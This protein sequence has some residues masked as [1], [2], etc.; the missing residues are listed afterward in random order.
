MENEK[1]KQESSKELAEKAMDS[2]ELPEG[3]RKRYIVSICVMALSVSFGN[4]LLKY[5]LSQVKFPHVKSFGD[6]YQAGIQAASNAWLD[7]G[8]IL[9]IVNFIALGH[10]LRYGPISLTTPLRSAAG[11]VGVPV[12]AVL[13]LGEHVNLMHWVGIVTITAGSILMGIS[14]GKG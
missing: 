14:G 4:I 1:E 10:A 8:I 7:L 11:F 3:A 5:G 9:L 6:I 13:L 12:L 2:G